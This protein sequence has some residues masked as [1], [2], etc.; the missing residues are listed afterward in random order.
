MPSRGWR[1]KLRSPSSLPEGNP[2]ARVAVQGRVLGMSQLPSPHPTI[3]YPH[4]TL[5]PG[6]T[7]RSFRPWK[8]S[9]GAAT[10]PAL[11]S[12]GLVHA[13]PKVNK[14]MELMVA[15]TGHEAGGELRLGI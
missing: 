10:E 12:R 4:R 5:L 7:D 9:L 2:S 11:L 3:M 14:S 1:C 8:T 13:S 15:D 6:S